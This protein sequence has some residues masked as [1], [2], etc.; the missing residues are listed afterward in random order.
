[1]T[2][3]EVICVFEK[4]WENI[5]TN[6]GNSVDWN[7]WYI[8][9][10]WPNLRCYIDWNSWLGC[11]NDL[12]WRATLIRKDVTE[13]FDDQLEWIFDWNSCETML[14]WPNLRCYVDFERM[15]KEDFTTN[16]RYNVDW[17]RCERMLSWPYLSLYVEKN[18]WY[19]TLSWLSLKC[20]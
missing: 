16:L 19:G 11:C 12:I 9:M 17:N 2:E 18:R 6:L 8:M 10:S 15:W 20:Y 14:V 3:S 4:R 5:T 1:M 7:R 13:W